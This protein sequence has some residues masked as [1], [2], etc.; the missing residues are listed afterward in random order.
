MVVILSSEILNK[1]DC[2]RDIFSLAK[3]LLVLQCVSR[4]KCYILYRVSFLMNQQMSLG[5]KSLCYWNSTAIFF[6]VCQLGQSF[7]IYAW[8]KKCIKD[9]KC[10]SVKYVLKHM[11]CITPDISLKFWI[12]FSV[13]SIIFRNRWLDKVAYFSELDQDVATWLIQRSFLKYKKI[14]WMKF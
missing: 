13:F 8:F 2:V 6:A 3:T 12:R 9:M 11:R 1:C 7:C 5:H 10:E 4:E 14:L